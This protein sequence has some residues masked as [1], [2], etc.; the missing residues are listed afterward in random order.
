MILDGDSRPLAK[1]ETLSP[2]ARQLYLESVER[3]GE[4]QSRIWLQYR[5]HYVLDDDLNPVPAPFVEWAVTFEYQPTERQIRVDNIGR[6]LVSTVFLGLDH[7]FNFHDAPNYRPILFETMTFYQR[8]ET[9]AHDQW[10]DRRCWRYCTTQEAIAGHD[11]AVE[12][13]KRHLKLPRKLKK[14][15]QRERE[16]AG[17]RV[18]RSRRDQQGQLVAAYARSLW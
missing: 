17:V 11:H 15:L 7:G 14:A 10:I 2:K 4:E 12:I 3:V 9:P 1:V 6:W 13:V 8:V 18:Q 5:D 16:Y